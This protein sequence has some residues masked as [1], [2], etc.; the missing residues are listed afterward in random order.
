[1][2]VIRNR[3]LGPD[4]KLLSEHAD[5]YSPELSFVLA[6]RYDE[7]GGRQT[8]MKYESIKAL[9]RGSPR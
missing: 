4:G 1:M 2:L 7:R 9:E 6:K 8:T 5:F 3:F